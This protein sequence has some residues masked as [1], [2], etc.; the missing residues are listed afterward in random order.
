MYNV[1]QVYAIQTGNIIWFLE[2][3]ITKGQYS[4]VKYD[5]I[6]SLQFPFEKLAVIKKTEFQTE[7][8]L[9]YFLS[10]LSQESTRMRVSYW[11]T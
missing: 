1:Q 6:L 8:P 3:E 11:Q 5:I 2:F 10:V 9:L 4:C 7:W